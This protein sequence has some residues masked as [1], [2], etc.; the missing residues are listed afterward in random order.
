MQYLMRAGTTRYTCS[1]ELRSTEPHDIMQGGVLT[2]ETTDGGFVSRGTWSDEGG[3]QDCTATLQDAPEKMF[4]STSAE[5]YAELEIIMHDVATREIA[6][7]RV[8]ARHIMSRPAAEFVLR[9]LQLD[10]DGYEAVGVRPS[11]LAHWDDPLI[12][13]KVANIEGHSG[14]VVWWKESQAAVSVTHA[15]PRHHEGVQSLQEAIAMGAGGI[16]CQ[17]GEV[18]GQRCARIRQR[19]EMVCV[20]WMPY[21][22][23]AS[24]LAAGNRGEYPG[25]GALRLLCDPDCGCS[26]LA[27]EEG[28]AHLHLGEE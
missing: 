18:T 2:I 23:R 8:A 9:A 13:V 12:P 14:W 4:R 15:G 1:V 7:S 21:Q 26:M 25:N 20:E 22:H 3:I 27:N 19:T 5:L 28:W 6:I 10:A 11:C 24:H 16:R 17:C